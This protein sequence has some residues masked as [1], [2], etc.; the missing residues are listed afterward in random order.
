MIEGG[1]LGV[2]VMLMAPILVFNESVGD[3]PPDVPQ[4]ALL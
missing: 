4:D 1:G 3:D 2:V